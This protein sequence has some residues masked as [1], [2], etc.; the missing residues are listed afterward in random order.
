MYSNYIRDILK[1]DTSLN[2]EKFYCGKIDNKFEKSICVY[3]LGNVNNLD[4]DIGKTENKT[5]T[6]K[7]QILI[8]WNKNYIETETASR[9]IYDYLTNIRNL[10]YNN[11]EINFIEP[12]SNIPID[13]H[14]GDDDIYERSIDIKI[15]FKEK[16][17]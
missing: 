6:N 1:L 14:S 3:D 10:S 7:Y 12:Q 13:L 11:I 5:L 8:R 16:N 2:I 17:E 9:K 15:Y 4:T